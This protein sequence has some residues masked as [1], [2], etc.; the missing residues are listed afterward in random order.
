VSAT[1]GFAELTLQARDRVAASATE[2]RG[3]EEHPGG[4]RSISF[5]DP[6]GNVVE[7]WDFYGRG[8]SSEELADRSG[9]TS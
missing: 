8:R 6:E 9:D 5:E 2:V 3:P 7:A 1:D 4:D